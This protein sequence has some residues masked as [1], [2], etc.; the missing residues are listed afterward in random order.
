M[1]V[2][3]VGYDKMLSA[4]VSGSIYAGHEVVG[5]L[6]ID[7]VNL[8]EFA[9]FLKDVFNPS[10]DFSILRAFG[11]YDIKAKSINSKE[12]IKEFKRLGAQAILVG[13]WGEKISKNVFSLPKY[14]TINCHPS[15]LPR[16]R[17]ANPY[18]WTI[19]NNEDIGGVTFHLVDEN[20]DTGDI[21]LQEA[22]TIDPAM[23]GT[24]LKDRCSKYAQGLVGELLTKL[25]KGEI[26]PAKQ[27]ETRATY[28]KQ[29]QFKDT[30][31]DLE[32]S[33]LE[34]H[35]RI[36]GLKSWYT[37]IIRHKGKRYYIKKHSFLELKEKYKNKRAGE[38]VF[39]NSKTAI[40]RTKEGILH[41]VKA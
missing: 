20:Y 13:S 35:N 7:R 5:A 6:R 30:I 36:R 37:P 2:I 33:N 32:K 21:L 9:L 12:F 18:F 40:F 16:H 39:E 31:I 23:T 22:V 41:I 25:E 1:K 15:L 10:H 8:S 29:I 38:L 26:K 19:L 24:E 11:V 3:V 14:G 34:I 17:G 28:E 27:D 4:L